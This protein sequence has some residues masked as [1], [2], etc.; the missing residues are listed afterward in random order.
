MNP[1]SP[2][3][4]LE[5]VAA[6][7]RYPLDAFQF[8]RF[9]LD[10]TVRRMHAQP[11]LLD[12]IDRHVTGKD[13][14][15]GLRDFAIQQ[16]GCLTR[17]MLARWNIHRTED[18]GHIVFAMVESGLMQA[19]EEDSLR[20]FADGYDFDGAFDVPICVDDVEAEN[21]IPDSAKHD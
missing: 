9:G 1:E 6:Q 13:L 14:C 21:S 3:P 19:T 20:D 4:S 10:F 15:E 16:Y 12:E 2:E 8:V 17:P 18:F 5:D 11:E 7:T